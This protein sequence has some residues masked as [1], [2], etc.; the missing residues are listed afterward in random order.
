MVTIY[1]LIIKTHDYPGWNNLFYHAFI[2]NTAEPL[3]KQ[4]ITIPMYLKVISKA[5][6]NIEGIAA[7]ICLLVI[8]VFIFSKKIGVNRGHRLYQFFY[9]VVITWAIIKTFL[10]PMTALRFIIPPV[11]LLFFVILK[12]YKLLKS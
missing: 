3:A 12:K 8:T 6:L 7:F 10:F 5:V 4:T 9:I 11:L 1:F 2:N